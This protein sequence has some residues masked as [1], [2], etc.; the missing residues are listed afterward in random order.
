MTAKKTTPKK[1]AAKKA[2]PAQD[3]ILE[4]LT[5]IEDAEEKLGAARDI[6]QE[7]TDFEPDGTTLLT[8]D[9]T[10]V[11]EALLA[12]YGEQQLAKNRS[13]S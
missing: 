8:E 6:A 12:K 3:P 7:H 1:P 11:K 9:M 5:L 13:K 4:A 2:K 10:D